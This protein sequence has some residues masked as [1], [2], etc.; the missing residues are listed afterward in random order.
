M[1]PLHSMREQLRKV[2]HPGLG[3]DAANASHSVNDLRKLTG[4][5]AYAPSAT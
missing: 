5:E 3:R 1:D 2:A 4:M